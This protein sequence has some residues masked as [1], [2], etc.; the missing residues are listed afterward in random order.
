MA[1]EESRLD[2]LV[3][4]KHIAIIMDGNGR[5]AKARGKKRTAGHREGSKTL[6]KI[7]RDAYELGVSYV[8]VYAFST[9]NW[10]RT[11]EEVDFLM[12]LLR[13][14]L[15]DSL[16]ESK[17]NNMCIKVIGDTEGLPIDIQKRIKELEEVS[18]QYDGLNLQIALNYG[19]RD[20]IVR[21]VKK[22]HKRIELGEINY[23]AIDENFISEQLDT[24][25]IPDPDL[26]I[27]TSGEVRLS[28]FLLWQLAYAEFYFT[29]KYWPD[30]D[31]EALEEAIIM[32]NKA[33]RRFGG[34][35]DE[36]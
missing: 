8:T 31:K 3:I 29:E 26:M 28:N 19:G 16:K 1:I 24:A 30:F 34:L 32:Y 18:E 10:K 14:Y 17:E 20:E 15:K 23:T 22:I 9:E 2:G 11:E 7:C 13:Q 27:R 5:W 36:T 35:N 6:K 25:G 12:K 21:A 4:P 33:E